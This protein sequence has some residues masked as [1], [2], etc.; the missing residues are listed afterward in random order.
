MN[1]SKGII[2]ESTAR[3]LFH[4]FR[5]NGWHLEEPRDQIAA[6]EPGRMKRLVMRALAEDLIS[7]SRAAELL[8]IALQEFT[9]KYVYIRPIRVL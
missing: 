8:G 4:K 2:S 5:K 1:I 9:E 3:G 6:E 7:P